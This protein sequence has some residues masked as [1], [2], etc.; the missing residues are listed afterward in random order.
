LAQQ[1]QRPPGPRGGTLR[2]IQPEV[3]EDEDA[4][5]GVGSRDA[6]DDTAEDLGDADLLDV[7]EAGIFTGVRRVTQQPFRHWP[8][9]DIYPLDPLD[10]P[11]LP[12]RTSGLP[13]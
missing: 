9:G 5:A 8:P 7:Y 6:D 4:A 11:N 12:H 2:A 3:D 1:A 10:I 13:P